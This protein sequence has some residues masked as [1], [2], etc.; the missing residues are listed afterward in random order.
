MLS[1]RATSATDSRR[2]DNRELTVSIADIAD[3]DVAANTLLPPDVACGL[4][5][6]YTVA[7]PT[8]SSRLINA[9]SSSGTKYWQCDNGSVTLKGEFETARS[10]HWDAFVFGRS[11]CAGFLVSLLEEI[12]LFS[13]KVVIPETHF[14][15]CVGNCCRVRAQSHFT[16]RRA[17]RV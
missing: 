6:E 15:R 10:P 4:A 13:K 7:L 5:G 11:K 2:F 9:E 14:A 16:S 12:D 8:E 1:E 3:I 17:W